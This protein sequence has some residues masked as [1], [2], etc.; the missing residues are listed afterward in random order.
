MVTKIC[1]GADGGFL[2]LGGLH[3]QHILKVRLYS[4]YM[5][6]SSYLKNSLL[7]ARL[8]HLPLRGLIIVRSLFQREGL[9]SEFNGKLSIENNLA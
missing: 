2:L 8:L 6:V 3:D 1:V 5:P 7:T 9:I 4:R